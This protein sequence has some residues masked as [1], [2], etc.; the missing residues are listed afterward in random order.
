ML[1]KK[2]GSKYLLLGFVI[3]MVVVSILILQ[4]FISA[5]FLSAILAF[6]FYPVYKKLTKLVRYK[7]ISAFLVTFGI[8]LLFIGPLVFFASI[9]FNE[10]MALFSSGMISQLTTSLSN[11][12]GNLSLAGY[13]PQITEEGLLFL[14]NTASSVLASIPEHFLNMVIVVFSIFFFFL[15]GEEI[16]KKVKELLPM[17][18]K[19][20]ILKDLKHTIHALVYGFFAV[21][22]IDFII[23]AIVLK[24]LGVSAPILWALLMAI[25]VLI[26]AIG[27]TIVYFPMTFYYAWMGNWWVAIGIFVMGFILSTIET[28]GRP[29][30][31]GKK[32]EINPILIMFGIFGGIA[33]FG[34]VGLIIGPIILSL[35]LSLIEGISK[36]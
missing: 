3:L 2:E 6:V 16:V 35:T 10:I 32:A 21:A 34:F 8:W 17:E 26:P 15:T 1:S 30:F 31:V 11:T 24:L 13:L 5:L 9:I 14:A 29:Y 36:K 19:D 33:I 7:Q 27:A 12:L 28:L 20:K 18:N 4:S 23:A 22:I 25:L